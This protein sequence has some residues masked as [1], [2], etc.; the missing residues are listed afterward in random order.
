M[1]AVN[2]DGTA[3]VLDAAPRGHAAA[4]RAHELVRHLRAGARPDGDRMR[5]SA[6]R[7]NV[8]V[9]YKR[10]KLDGERLALQAA[11]TAPT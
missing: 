11:G 10:T 9:P 7:A 5:P 1:Q 6:A 8:R 2:V 4:G 3:V